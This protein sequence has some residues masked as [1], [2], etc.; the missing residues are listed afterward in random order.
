MS[1]DFPPP[2][3]VALQKAWRLLRIVLSLIAVAA[4]AVFAA[5]VVPA[6]GSASDGFRN[7]VIIFFANL[8][9]VVIAGQVHQE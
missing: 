1:P 9:I 8:Q 5:V 6:L 2:V 3:S 4:V 7:V